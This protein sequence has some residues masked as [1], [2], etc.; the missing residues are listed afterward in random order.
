[1]LVKLFRAGYLDRFRP[2]SRR[3]SYPWTYQLGHEGHRMLRAARAIPDSNRFKPRTIHDFGY[4][5]HDL[6]LNA[7]VLAWRR[8]LGS[9]LVEWHGET[10]IRPPAGLR[11]EDSPRVEDDWSVERL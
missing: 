9:A 6:Q 4:V 2:L 10:E 3:G 11:A 1:R 5:V 8:V 7:W